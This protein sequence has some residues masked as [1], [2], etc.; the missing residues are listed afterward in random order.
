MRDYEPLAFTLE[1][2]NSLYRPLCVYVAAGL[3][4]GTGCCLLI[5]MGFRKHS[6][7]RGLGNWHRSPDD[8][9]GGGGG[10]GASVGRPQ[11][12]CTSSMPS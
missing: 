3:V 10:G 9:N 12:G 6:C 7:G 5:A 4:R 2:V 8:I 1:G 11:R